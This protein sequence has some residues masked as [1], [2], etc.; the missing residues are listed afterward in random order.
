MAQDD[1][2]ARW[3]FYEQLAGVERLAFNEGA[4]APTQAPS[5]V[6]A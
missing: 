2:N 6:K 5:E 1:I 4:A 3:H